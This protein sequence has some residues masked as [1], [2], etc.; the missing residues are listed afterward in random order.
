[1]GR[2]GDFLERL[3]GAGRDPDRERLLAILGLNRELARAGDRRALL[4]TLVDHAVALFGAERGFLLCPEPDAAGFRVEVAR[5]LDREPVRAP[6]RKVSSTV[7]HKALRL[8]AG[9]FSEDAQEG[10]LGAA[11]SVAD[12]K[13]RSVLCMPVRVGERVLGCIYLDHR[14]QSGAF[15]PDDLPWLQAFA[16]QAA[17][18]LHLHESWLNDRQRAEALAER[19]RALQQTVAAQAEELAAMQ[20]APRSELRHPFPEVIGQAPALVRALHVL[21]RVVDADFPLL[22]VG[23]SGTGKEVVV[24]AVHAAGPRARAPFVAVNVAAISPA[25]LESE[26]F[27]HVKGAFTGADRERQ[28]LLREAHGGTLFLDEVTEMPPDLQTKLLRFLQDQRVRPV[29][30]D[31]ET[32]VDL[33]VVA[34]TNRDPLVAVAAGALREDLYY[35]LAVV[36]VVL[37]PLRERASDIP[38]LC[39][40]FLS[41]IDGAPPELPADVLAAMRHRHWPGNV[42]QLKNEVQRLCALARGSAMTVRMLSPDEPP[43]A[44]GVPQPGLE[45][46]AVERWAVARA[47]RAAG[48]NKAQAARLLGISRRTLYSKLGESGR[49]DAG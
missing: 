45:L 6:E 22:L 42:R 3:R 44:S 25:L 4:S 38:E 13:L 23:E 28:G 30:G 39:R 37:P 48:G 11:Q 49:D 32:A 27:G 24:R 12:L 40:H 16:D 33:R 9:V 29:G 15:A 5:S 31:R 8:G 36:T 20:S 2:F 41:G 43:G 26:L 35:R 14:F 10:E 47:L 1:V 17:I 19:N 21:D 46:E 7:V 34:A 18:A